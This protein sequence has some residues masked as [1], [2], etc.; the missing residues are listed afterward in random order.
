MLSLREGWEQSGGDSSPDDS[1]S[2]K[3]TEVFERG[4]VSG[5]KSSGISVVIGCD[6]FRGMGLVVT[7]CG[8]L[9]RGAGFLPAPA[10]WLGVTSRCVAV[11]GLFRLFEPGVW[12]ALVAER[13]FLEGILV[14]FV[15][16][17]DALGTML[18][19]GLV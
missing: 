11:V 16:G 14:M 3:F 12:L 4:E 6:F 7:N 18:N 10:P 19:E 13:P 8:T 17:R 9:P 5:L 15:S 2:S 1:S